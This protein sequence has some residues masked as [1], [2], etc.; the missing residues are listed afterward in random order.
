MILP[1]DTIVSLDFISDDKG[2]NPDVRIEPTGWVQL[3]SELNQEWNSD[4]QKRL[5]T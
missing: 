2:Y 5:L 4:S 3:M 1:E